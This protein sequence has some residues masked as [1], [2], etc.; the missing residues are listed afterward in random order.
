MSPFGRAAI[1]VAAAALLSH[2]PALRNGFT[3][4][5]PLLVS[6]NAVVA[7][8]A[9]SRVF[10]SPY[11]VGPLQ[12]V[13]T[14]LYR[15]LTI[16]TLVA[17]HAIGGGAPWS[18]HLGNLL[19]HAGVA[20]L[21]LALGRRLALPPPAPL[22]GALLFAVHPAHAEAV[23]SVA[24][25]ADLLAAGAAL[26][27]LLFLGRPL[28]FGTLL[29]VSLLA[30]ET[31]LLLP[32]AALVGTGE[33]RAVRLRT[34][35]AGGVAGALYLAARTAVLGG[36]VLPGT[37]GTLLE[38]PLGVL[39]LAERLPAAAAVALRALGLVVFPRHLSPD[40]GWAETGA[41]PFAAGAVAVTVLLALA[42]G[43]VLLAARSRQAAL[44]LTV[45][46]ASWLLVSNTV[47]VIGTAFGERLLYLPLAAL[48]LLA[49]WGTNQVSG[50]RLR[51]GGALAVALLLAVAA[52]RSWTASAAWR[53]DYTLARAAE[54]ATPRSVKVLGNLAVELLTRGR[55]AEGKALLDRALALA[56]GA[57]PLLLNRASLA[58]REGDVAEAE[59]RIATVLA[60]DPDEP[61]ALLLS[62]QVAERRGDLSAAED[63][64]RRAVARRPGWP[65][66]AAYL[67]RIRNE[68]RASSPE[69]SVPEGASRD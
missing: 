7:G 32:L 23:A 36:L 28:I 1:L 19:L 53:D 4:D 26:G 18:F 57:T 55:T 52:A 5:D 46:A 59:R 45:I 44:L 8:E 48:S 33:A 60:G 62:A 27:A 37:R 39:S 69:G 20:L 38:N 58:L 14:G 61:M 22:L 35:L 51:R 31:A 30:K 9:W 13:P 63:A 16:L 67:E 68:R 6:E 65:A 66:P 29:L 11:H 41:V 2:L 43:A 50:P 17:D 54:K 15:P 3:F 56:P 42:T 25:R 40:Y 47:I 64:L 49:A 10:Q 12:T 24:G 34:F 21:V